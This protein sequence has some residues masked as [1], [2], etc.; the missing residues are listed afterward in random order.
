MKTLKAKF[1]TAEAG[2]PCDED[3]PEDCETKGFCQII[4]DGF[5]PKNFSESDF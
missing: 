4:S 2:G 5:E 1:I 3:I